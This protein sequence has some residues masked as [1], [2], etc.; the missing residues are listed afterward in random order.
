MFKW[1][2]KYPYIQKLIDDSDFFWLKQEK[3]VIEKIIYNYEIELWKVFSSEKTKNIENILEQE[4]KKL[5][6]IKQELSKCMTK[7]LN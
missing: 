1:N 5:D 4:R 2:S 6:Y 3:C 7:L